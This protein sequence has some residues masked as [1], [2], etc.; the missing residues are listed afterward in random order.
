VTVAGALELC[1]ISRSMDD[2]NV[3]IENVL[4]R[5]ST[6]DP[7]IGRLYKDDEGWDRQFQTFSTNCLFG[8]RRF[9]DH[10]RKKITKYFL[11]VIL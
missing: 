11:M 3:T 6:A 4:K 9:A 7:S 1:W 5:K 10:L 8:L 2:A